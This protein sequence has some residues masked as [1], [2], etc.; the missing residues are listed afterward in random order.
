LCVSLPLA[1]LLRL[2][3]PDYI[4][5]ALFCSKEGAAQVRLKIGLVEDDSGHNFTFTSPQPVAIVEREKFKK[6]LTSIISRNRSSQDSLP[7]P[8]QPAIALLSP[9]VSALAAPTPKPTITPV[10]L[11]ESRATSVANERRETP[12]ITSSDPASDFRLRKKV[13]MSN[14]ELGALHRDLVMSGQIT[15]ADFWD[16]REVSVPK[17]RM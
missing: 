5:T 7:Q 15:E 2:P 17:V 13:L 16:G 8:T 10:R 1:F 3:V 9:R 11:S 6:E 14:P 4:Y 12:I